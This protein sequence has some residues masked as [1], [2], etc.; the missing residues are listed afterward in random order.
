ME[1]HFEQMSGLFMFLEIASA[2]SKS[3]SEVAVLFRP[4]DRY[5][6]F[7]LLFDESIRQAARKPKRYYFRC[8]CK[9]NNDRVSCLQVW[10][11][12][13]LCLSFFLIFRAQHSKAQF[14]IP[15]KDIRDLRKSVFR[16]LDKL[17]IPI[18]S[19]WI[20]KYYLIILY[21]QFLT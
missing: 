14:Y 16:I 3:T 18:L 1:K 5:L 12:E 7:F 20:E 9:L 11:D 10:S 4:H 17:F 13:P 21:I 15:A 2:T 6:V 8:A 19:F